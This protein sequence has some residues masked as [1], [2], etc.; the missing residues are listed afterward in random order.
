MSQAQL[1]ATLDN[2]ERAVAAGACSVKFALK[3]AAAAGSGHMAAQY[4]AAAKI[5]A[6]AL[7]TVSNET[8]APTSGVSGESPVNV[9]GVPVASVDA[10]PEIAAATAASGGSTTPIYGSSSES[11][12][13]TRSP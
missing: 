4:A 9:N 10:P 3:S 8:T 1:E 12:N 5:A 2:L 7:S 6:Q 13:S 11:G